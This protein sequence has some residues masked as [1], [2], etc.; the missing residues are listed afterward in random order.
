[1]QVLIVEHLFQQRS[2][3]SGHSFCDA[4]IFA[5]DIESSLGWSARNT[6]CF[7]KL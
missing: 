3:G 6:S 7:G 1:M 2:N 5:L 4:R